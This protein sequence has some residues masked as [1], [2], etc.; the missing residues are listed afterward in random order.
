MRW[1]VARAHSC[2]SRCLGGTCSAAPSGTCPQGKRQCCHCV[3]SRSC[4]LR[5]TGPRALS[6]QL[7]CIP[8]THH[9]VSYTPTTMHLAAG[10]NPLAKHPAAGDI[11][12]SHAP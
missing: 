7:C 11:P 4:P 6:C 3:T 12:L 9:R 8:A 2:W 10:D 1:P 5:L